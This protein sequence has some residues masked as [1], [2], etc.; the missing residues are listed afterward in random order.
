[1]CANVLRAAGRDICMNEERSRD[2]GGRIV[3]WHLLCP[4][5]TTLDPAA[6]S[7]IKE[8]PAKSR[9]KQLWVLCC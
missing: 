7:S 2:G 9:I 5:K 6:S 3:N 8:G 4:A 1:M